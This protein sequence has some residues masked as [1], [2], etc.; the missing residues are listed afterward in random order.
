MMT[1]YPACQLFPLSPNFSDKLSLSHPHRYAL[2]EMTHRASCFTEGVLAMERTV[3]GIL[4]VDAR[5]VLH[6][7]LRAE[8][9]RQVSAALHA[10][11]VFVN[12]KT[13]TAS[14]T[15]ADVRVDLDRCLQKL[16]HVMD[17]FR[18]SVEYLQV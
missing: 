14:T 4:Q 1:A 6:D 11:L 16:A 9:V 2:A 5:Q 17:G 12:G 8:L 10:T 3:L 15:K 13:S 7:G 18:R